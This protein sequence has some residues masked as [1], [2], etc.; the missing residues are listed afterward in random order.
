MAGMLA[1]QRLKILPPPML[2]RIRPCEMPC[3]L[4]FYPRPT[5]IADIM[6]RRER[7]DRCLKRLGRP[8]AASFLVTRHPDRRPSQMQQPTTAENGKNSYSAGTGF[9][10]P[11]G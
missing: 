8:V 6:W 9:P 1:R 10:C 11:P 4:V 5:P 7:H 2:M 3:A